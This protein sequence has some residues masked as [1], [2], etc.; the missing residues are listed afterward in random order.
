MSSGSALLAILLLILDWTPYFQQWM[1][2]NSE[3][4][5]PFHKLGGERVKMALKA[6]RT[7]S[8]KQPT[9]AVLLFSESALG[10]LTRMDK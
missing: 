8:T 7:A 2:P 4:E 9:K 6:V 5:N 10:I 3:M 1:L